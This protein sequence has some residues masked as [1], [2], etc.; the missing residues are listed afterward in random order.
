MLLDRIVSICSW[1]VVL[2]NIVEY[3]QIFSD[4]VRYSQIVSYIVNTFHG[5]FII[6]LHCS[7]EDLRDVLTVSK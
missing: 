4:I 7:K 6:A 2:I 5:C 3:C 1:I